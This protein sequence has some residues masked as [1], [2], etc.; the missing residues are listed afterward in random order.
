MKIEAI[1]TILLIVVLY[2]IIILLYQG[3]EGY[4][5]FYEATDMNGKRI[6]V[7]DPCHQCIDPRYSIGD[8]ILIPNQNHAN[9]IPVLEE[10]TFRIN[11]GVRKVII[12]KHLRW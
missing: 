1:K 10:D 5:D 4:K 6:K 9:I 7:V 2:L 11:R 8:T 12:S 3:C